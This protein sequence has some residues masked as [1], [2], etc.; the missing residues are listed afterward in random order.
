MQVLARILAAL[1]VVILSACALGDVDNSAAP[2]PVTVLPPPALDFTGTCDN[3]KE[4]ES[5]LQTSTLITTDFQTRLNAA[6]AKSRAD[7]HPDLIYLISA[8][9]SAF[10]APAPDCA[11]DVHLLLTD[12]LSRAVLTLQEYVNGTSTD[13]S[14]QLA[15]INGL[16]DQ[17]AS[18]QGVLLTRME[19]QF[20]QQLL[21]T[22]T[23]A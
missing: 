6:A 9:D 4:L 5:W 11:A 10:L 2:P 20:Q 14:T 3:T 16:L 13:I 15:E 21:V 12:T 23:P 18:A 19:A 1:L 22:P 17:I 7:A 8:R